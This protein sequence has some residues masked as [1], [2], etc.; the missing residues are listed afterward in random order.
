MI[1]KKKS[2]PDSNFTHRH[3]HDVERIQ[4]V[5]EQN[6][7]EADLEACAFLWDEYSD[8]MCAGWLGLPDDNEE[9]WIEIQQQA[10]LLSNMIKGFDFTYE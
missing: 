5:C 9:L 3:L 2:T 10:R 7:Y 6:G 1:F 8:S 4:Q